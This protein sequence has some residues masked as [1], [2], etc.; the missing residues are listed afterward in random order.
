MKQILLTYGLLRETVAVIN[1]KV[2]VGSLDGETDFFDIVASVLQGDTSTLFAH[3]LPWLLTSNVDRSD[4]KNGF[5]LK[6]KKAESRWYSA[7]TITDADY[8]DDIVL[9]ADT[10]TQAES[11][12]HSLEQAVLASTWMQ[13]KQ[14]TC[15]LNKE[16]SLL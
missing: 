12:L 2:K 11:L 5:T 14:S 16:T 9:L 8:A 15:V 4:E 3:Y 13:A 10:P 6:K 7:Q 1:T